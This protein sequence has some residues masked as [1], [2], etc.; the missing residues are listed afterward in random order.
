[1]K[2]LEDGSQADIGNWEPGEVEALFRNLS[3]YFDQSLFNM[4]VYHYYTFGT[5]AHNVAAY[6]Q[7][8]LDELA[9]YDEAHRTGE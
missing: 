8:A 1:L 3:K 6:L 7:R 5:S 4:D 2:E 9:T